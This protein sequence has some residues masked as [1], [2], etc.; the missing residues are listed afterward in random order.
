M[1]YHGRYRAKVMNGEG[2]NCANP[3][4]VRLQANGDS[5][6]FE[7]DGS[8]GFPEGDVTNFEAVT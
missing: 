6:L 2:L 8:F 4:N 5:V 1:A 3:R 7:C